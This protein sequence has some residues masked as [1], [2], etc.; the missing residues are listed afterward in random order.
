VDVGY[1]TAAGLAAGLVVGWLLSRLIFRQAP[2]STLAERGDGFVALAATFL[3]YG[4]AELLEGYGFVAVFACACSIR[5]AEREHGYH[6]V[7][8]GFIEQIERL[9]TVVVLVLLG[10][11][12]ARGLLTPLTLGDVAISLALVFVLRPAFGWLALVAAPGTRRERAA[13]A[14]FGVRGVGS[15][16]YLAF[17]IERLGDFPDVDRLWAVVGLVVTLSVVVHGISAQPAMR[18]VDAKREERERHERSR[19]WLRRRSAAD[20]GG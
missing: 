7:L 2:G 5:A 6:G 18:H 17:G 15:I 16:Y 8:H 10:G 12:I 19:V 1:R 20:S 4:A 3:A 13:I 9:V 14:F 11:A